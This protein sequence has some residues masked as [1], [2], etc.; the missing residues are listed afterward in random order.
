M[1]KQVTVSE[2]E[3]SGFAFGI[4]LDTVTEPFFTIEDKQMSIFPYP[5]ENFF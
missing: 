1:T 3:Y 4:G 2:V 5:N